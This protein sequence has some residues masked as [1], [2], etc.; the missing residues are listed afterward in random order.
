MPFASTLM[1]AVAAI[2]V[3]FF[4]WKTGKVKDARQFVGAALVILAGATGLGILEARAEREARQLVSAVFPVPP[5]ASELVF[6]RKA[7]KGTRTQEVEA[8]YAWRSAE[9]FPVTLEDVSFRYRLNTSATKF[10]I[11]T[12][13]T[14]AIAGGALDWKPLP[15]PNRANRYWPARGHVSSRNWPY[16]RDM[17][18][19]YLCAVVVLA[20]ENASSPQKV[21]PCETLEGKPAHSVLILAVHD[22]V[23]GMLH[24]VVR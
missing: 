17:S 1:M 8:I 14:F 19:S 7:T 16:E 2:A 3:L 11:W 15:R 24:V 22:T 18:G 5:E 9:P 13:D 10:G 20:P 21:A 23:A 12:I 4:F 6:R